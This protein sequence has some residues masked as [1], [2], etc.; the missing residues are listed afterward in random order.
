MILKLSYLQISDFETIKKWKEQASESSGPD[1][2][3]EAAQGRKR[4]YK[5][6]E[7]PSHR[8]SYCVGFY[9]SMEC[10]PKGAV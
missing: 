4:G 7:A 8:V 3:D 6:I 5:W 10:S 9:Y 2:T 1:G